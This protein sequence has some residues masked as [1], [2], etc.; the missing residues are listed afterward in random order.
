MVYLG[1]DPSSRAYLLGS[2]F[3]LH[4][5]VAVEVT[6]FEAIFPFRKFKASDSPASLLWGSESTLNAGDPRHGMFAEQP[7]GMTKFLDRSALKSLGAIPTPSQGHIDIATFV[8]PAPTPTS[9]SGDF[10]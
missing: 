7:D 10:P 9:V 4:T 2:L 3:D 5:S 6:F 1:I 8:E